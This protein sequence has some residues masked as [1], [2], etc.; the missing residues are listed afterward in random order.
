M[1]EA[2]SALDT[3][4]EAAVTTAIRSLRGSM[5]IITVAHRLS[6]VVDSDIIFFM[7]KGRVVANGTFPELV[8]A[9]P[10]FAAQAALAGLTD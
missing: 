1:D 7:S 6:T 10:E 5:T 8:K 9:V 2:T 3:A 4:T